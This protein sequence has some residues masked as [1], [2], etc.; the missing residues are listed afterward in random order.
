MICARCQQPIRRD[1][2]YETLEK[3]SDSGAGPDFHVHKVCP[4]RERH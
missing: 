1:Q 3:F 4:P 2:D